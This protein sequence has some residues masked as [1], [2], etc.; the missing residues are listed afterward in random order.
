[1]STPHSSGSQPGEHQP[2]DYADNRDAA[3]ANQYQYGGAPG[4]GQGGYQDQGSQPG[5]P[6]GPGQAIKRFY[7][8]YAQV[9]GRASRSEYWWVALYMF[10]IYVVLLV[11]I[12]TVGS[13]SVSS[14][15]VTSATSYSYSWESE[16][17]G[18]GSFLSLVLVVF[19]LGHIIP[20]IALAVRRL[21]DANMSGLLYL[22]VLIPFFGPLI[23]L[24]FYLLPSNPA[25]ARFDR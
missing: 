7:K 3:A 16:P 5:V 2:R 23:L 17:N 18:L 24:V 13:E 12:S 25:G 11:L 1:M 19:L 4:Y 10:L 22:L 8:K 21:H 6:V 14:N 15:T 20:S 9:S